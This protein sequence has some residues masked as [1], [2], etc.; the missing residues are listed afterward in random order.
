M[1]TIDRN[2]MQ[3]LPRPRKLAERGQSTA[4]LL[5]HAAALLSQH[6]AQSSECRTTA[7]RLRRLVKQ[8]AETSG[9][10]HA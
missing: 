5:L 2:A 1:S 4:D 10:K 8:F 7:D 6:G 9:G 3:A